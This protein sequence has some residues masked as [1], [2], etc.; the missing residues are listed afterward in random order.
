MSIEDL[1]ES[2]V[3]MEEYRS[4]WAVLECGATQTLGGYS[5]LEQLVTDLGGVVKII[6]GRRPKF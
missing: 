6:P 3:A 5:A 2:Y 1:E 4:R